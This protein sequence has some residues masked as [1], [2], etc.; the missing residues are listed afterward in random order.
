[1]KSTDS[2]CA[3]QVK[4]VV[5]ALALFLLAGCESWSPSR[6]Q[7][8][9]IVTYKEVIDGRYYLTYET[10]EGEEGGCEV[11]KEVYLAQS[12]RDSSY[13]SGTRITPGDVCL[14]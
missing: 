3:N 11:A 5:L 4:C 12:F 13:E 2:L 9:A 8:T 10:Y 6:Y 7:G 14:P 1:M